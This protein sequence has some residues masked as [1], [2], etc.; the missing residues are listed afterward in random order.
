MSSSSKKLFISEDRNLPRALRHILNM[1]DLTL[2]MVAKGWRIK[3]QYIHAHDTLVL[4]AATILSVVC[5]SILVYDAHELE[6]DK[7]GQ[8]SFMRHGT[9]AIEKI[10]WPRVNKF[11]TV[12][13][14]IQNWYFN[15]FSE[16]DSEIIFNSPVNSNF[17]CTDYLREH[18]SIEQSARVFIYI[19]YLSKGRG[20]NHMLKAFSEPDTL[21]HI[22]FLGDGRLKGQI[23]QYGQT[24]KNIHHHDPVEHSEVVKIASSAD[25]GLCLIENISVS[26]YFSLP[27]KLF[28]Y[29]F[30][31]LKVI[32][33]DFP[34][35]RRV[36]L[37]HNAG[38]TCENSSEA[39]REALSS[40]DIT[41]KT[42][43]LSF[44]SWDY[45]ETKLKDLYQ[46]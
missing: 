25:V 4:P 39:L 20:I 12:S 11:I 1:L 28:E 10:C 15:R 41:E 3:P 6:S 38:I 44:L 31:G 7:N 23:L 27:N 36:L 17:E 34:E 21:N 37:E 35:I 18:F 45:Q 33:S 19:G 14:S 16:K 8:N 2:Y 24:F 30:S 5:G 13:E 40:V 32:G 22:V 26:D 9:F 46:R 42:G 43:D 29:L